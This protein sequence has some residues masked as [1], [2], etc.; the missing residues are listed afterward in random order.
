MR[1]AILSLVLLVQAGAVLGAALGAQAAQAVRPAAAILSYD[2]AGARLEMT[3]ADALAALRAGGFEQVSWSG[4]AEAPRFWRYSLGET[5]VE[6]SQAEGVI[7]SIR[8]TRRSGEGRRLDVAAEL[9]AIK[10]DFGLGAEDC[11]EK[12]PQ[13]AV[14]RVVD[15]EPPK[16]SL[17]AEILG[18]F[19]VVQAGRLP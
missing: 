16:L 15:G 7:T 4:E 14:C 3:P 5:T 17:T 13:A 19:M 18:G 1:L 11:L 8:Y 2:L 9:A 10:A 6:V 12:L